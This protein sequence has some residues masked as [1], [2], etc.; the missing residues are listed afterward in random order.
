KSRLDD[1]DAETR[2]RLRDIELLDGRH[3]GARRLLA[4]AQ[5][6]IEDPDS[7]VHVP[8][9]DQSPGLMV[10]GSKNGIMARSSAPT[11]SMR[12]SRSFP[13][14][15]SKVGRPVLFPSIHFFANVPSWISARIFFIVSRVRS[16]TTRG[17]D[18]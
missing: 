6:R 14:S 4:V 7:V 13:R 15:A 1:V 16:S 5:G 8:L 17:P 3:R 18:T 10:T 12:S 11:F 2:E 9:A